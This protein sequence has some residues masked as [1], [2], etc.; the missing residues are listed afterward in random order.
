MAR[1]AHRSG[2]RWATIPARSGPRTGG[3]VALLTSA[4][5][6]PPDGDTEHRT[7][8]SARPHERARTERGRRFVR[9]TAAVIAGALLLLTGCNDGGTSG[10]SDGSSAGAPPAQVA[11]S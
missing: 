10:A 3:Q 5:L 2:R 1:G 9:R 8:M 4:P 6:C 7:S 11:V